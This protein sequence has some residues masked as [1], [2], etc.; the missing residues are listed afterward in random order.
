MLGAGIHV[1]MLEHKILQAPLFV[2]SVLRAL[3][4]EP[5]AKTNIYLFHTCHF[6]NLLWALSVSRK[7]VFI[8]VLV[9]E[10]S[11]HPCHFLRAT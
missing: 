11:F 4:Q 7:A 1:S 3:C 5:E 9:P 8:L 10:I 2:Q 6:L